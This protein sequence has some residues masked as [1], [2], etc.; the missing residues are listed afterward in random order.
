[1]TDGAALFVRF[2]GTERDPRGRFPGVFALANRLARSGRLDAAQYRFWRAGNDWYD[3][4]VT[5]PSQV[6]PRVYDPDVHPGATAWFKTTSAE[7]VAR[8][9]GYLELLASHGVP[10][11]RVESPSPGRVVYEDAD[12]IVVVPW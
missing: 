6:D 7:P 10:C 4:H 5:D 3:A 12:Q 9:T 1:M 11:R 2:Q 8:V